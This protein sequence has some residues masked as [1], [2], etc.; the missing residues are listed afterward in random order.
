MKPSANSFTLLIIVSIIIMQ[1]FFCG[2]GSSGGGNSENIDTTYTISGRVMLPEVSQSLRLS[3]ISLEKTTVRL[4]QQP[5]I[6]AICDKDGYFKLIVP[7]VYDSINL[8]VFNGNLGLDNFYLQKSD[9]IPLSNETSINAGK[10]K[11][12]ECKNTFSIKIKDKYN[13][14]IKYA[15]C[16]FWGFELSSDISGIITFPLFPENIKQ[17]KASINAAGYKELTNDYSVF[18]KDCGPCT[19]VI[20]RSID[21]N[22]S[23]VILNFEPFDYEPLPNQQVNL[24]L[25]VTDPSKVLGNSYSVRWI[26]TDGKLLK[27]D[28]RNTNTWQAPANIGLATVTATI[29]IEGYESSVSVG[30]AVGK[31]R[32]VN[33]KINS[34][35]PNK[36]AAGQTL[37]INGIGFG[38]NK[39]EVYFIGGGGQVLSWSDTQIKVIVPD[40]AETGKITI[41]TGNK[42]LTSE[43]EFTCIDYN[44]TLSVKYGVPGTEVS[45]TGYG[46]G[47][48]KAENSEILYYDEKINN[49]VSWS[50]RLIKFKVEELTGAMPHTANLDLIIRGRKRSLGDFTVSY[51]KSISPEEAN[52]FTYESE[53]EKTLITITGAGFGDTNEDENGTAKSSVR[54]LSY[55]DNNTKEYI[56]AEISSWSDNEIEV[57][58]PSKAQTGNIILKINDYE[59]QGPLFT[60]IP[61]NGYSELESARFSDKIDVSKSL[62]TGVIVKDN[63]L[64]YLCDPENNRLWYLE[65]DEYN[66]ILTTDATNIYKPYTGALTSDGDIILSDWE[67]KTIIK[68]VDGTIAQKS[69]YVFN[70]SPMGICI[71]P[72]TGNIYVA[73]SGADKIVIF[74]E[75]LVCIGSFGTTGIGNGQFSSP[76]GV[77]LNPTETAIF[78]ADKDNYRVQQFNISSDSSGNKEYKFN[79]WYGSY[80]GSNG[81]HA[82]GN[83]FGESS[84]NDL[85]FEAPTSVACDGTYLYVADSVRNDIQKIHLTNITSQILGEEGNGT[86]QF[87][88]PSDLKLFDTNMYIADSENH[89]MQI[90]SKTGN[91]VSQ[92]KPEISGVNVSFLGISLN[93]DKDS[94]YIVDTSDCSISKFDT[95]GTFEKKIGSK[96]YGAG[97]LLNPSDV[98][99][100]KE[101]N[102]WVADT[103]NKRL[104]MFPSD[105]SEAKSFGTGGSGTGQFK[106][107]QRLAC[108]SNGNIFVSDLDNNLVLKFNKSGEYLFSIGQSE[109]KE[110]M[111]LVVDSNDNLYVCDAGNHRVCKYDANN[112][113]EGW[114]GLAKGQ[115]AGG[116][117]E[118]DEKSEGDSGS[119]PCQFI[120]PAYLDIDNSNCLYVVD[121]GNNRI[122]KLDTQNTGVLGGHICT[123]DVDSD[124]Y[125]LALDDK[126][127]FFITTNSFVRKYVPTP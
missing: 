122:Q 10:I 96:G 60:V 39:G 106:S 117:H 30:L 22:K 104:V 101:D 94:I 11:L 64:I 100:D 86:F 102:I 95:Y 27:T 91:F 20:L 78:V 52:H 62:I 35:S 40:T 33:T 25:N 81:K 13:N 113:F 125:G 9:T 17:V 70:G 53:I 34:F 80:N 127:C 29:S 47:D 93:K 46:F 123:I 12:A 54:F 82:D 69:S 37:T 2:C 28:E 98:L 1:V 107:P 112:Q 38:I 59:I 110:P 85:G 73:D 32:T 115:E 14:P 99:L 67:N 103:G 114:F 6:Y 50:N 65:N 121:Y 55:G 36:A 45:I 97:Q 124:V 61:P 79:C 5:A 56:D 16:T 24:T 89:R 8:I 18:S 126:D 21:E 108:D 76:Y 68:L 66:Y 31:S 118:A 119:S 92:Q 42:T 84:D 15:K 87:M 58:L 111:G 51:I 71:S 88:A 19:E 7:K 109:L 77:C 43:E 44:I 26:C 72:S 49:I 75:N 120:A 63:D 83:E 74:D 105:G 23:P 90:I 4:E 3:Q 41:K 116:W 57:Y 48:T